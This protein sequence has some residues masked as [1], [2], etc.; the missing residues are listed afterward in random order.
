[1]TMHLLGPLAVFLAAYS[2]HLGYITVF[3]HRALAHEKLGH[4]AAAAQDWKLARDWIGRE[5]DETLY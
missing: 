1:M 3:Y 2:L 4:T 5:P